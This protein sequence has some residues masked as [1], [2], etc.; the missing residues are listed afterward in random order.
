MA[1]NY[2]NYLTPGITTST[3]VYNPTTAGIQATLIGLLISNTSSTSALV[4]VTMSSGTTTASIITN[5]TISPG[6]SLNVIDAS[7]II[8]AQNNIVRV[9]S[10]VP[11]DV[12]VSTIEVT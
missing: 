10:S 8:I 6:T 5:V 7:K 3:V 2:R 1:I 4:T 11:S 12:I 9:V